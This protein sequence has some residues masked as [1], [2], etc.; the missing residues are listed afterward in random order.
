MCVCV[1]STRYIHTSVLNNFCTTNYI[2]LGSGVGMT[3]GIQKNVKIFADDRN[4]RHQEKKI[5]YIQ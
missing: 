5:D 1:S 2:D 4:S 3:F